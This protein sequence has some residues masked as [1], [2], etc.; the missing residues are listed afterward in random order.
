MSR[1]AEKYVANTTHKLQFSIIDHITCDLLEAY[2]YLQLVVCV[3]G[4][5]DVISNNT[6]G[7]SNIGG[8]KEISNEVIV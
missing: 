8:M 4:Q 7:S 2:E 1:I 5:E 6:H 3:V